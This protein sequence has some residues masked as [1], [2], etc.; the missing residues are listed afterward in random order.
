MRFVRIRARQL[1]T[2]IDIYGD[3]V[4]RQDL[5]EIFV[6]DSNTRRMLQVRQT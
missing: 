5:V 6:E 2:I 3:L 1:S 4:K